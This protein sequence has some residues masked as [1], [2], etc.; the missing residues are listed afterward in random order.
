VL[1]NG[2]RLFIGDPAIAAPFTT[3]PLALLP[4]FVVPLVIVTHVLLFGTPP[5]K[6]R[7]FAAGS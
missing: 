1:A 6:P 3:L 2:A 7:G 4:T 5:P